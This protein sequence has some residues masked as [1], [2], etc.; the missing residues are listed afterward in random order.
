MIC[1]MNAS[2]AA[3]ISQAA[4]SQQSKNEYLKD[5]LVFINHL[6]RYRCRNKYFL[7]FDTEYFNKLEFEINYPHSLYFFFFFKGSN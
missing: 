6:A 4:A 3:F 1:K 2:H 5:N 7:Q